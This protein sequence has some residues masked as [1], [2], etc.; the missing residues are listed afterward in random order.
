MYKKLQRHKLKEN[1]NTM[2]YSSVNYKIRVTMTIEHTN[3]KKETIIKKIILTTNIKLPCAGPPF[4]TS[5]C[6]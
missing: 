5:Y 3:E 6:Y 2:Q 1:R 4:T